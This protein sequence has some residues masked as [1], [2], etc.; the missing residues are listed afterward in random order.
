MFRMKKY[1]YLAVFFSGM[2]SLAA[3]FGAS[4]LLGNYFGTSNIIWACIIGLILIYLTVGYFLGGKWA[5]RSPKFK[6]FFTILCWAAF[7]VGL[8]PVVSRP[9]LILASQAFEKL[10]FGILIGAFFSV[11]VLFSIPVTLLGTASPFAIRLSVEDKKTAGRI[12]GRIYAISTLGSFLG[13]FLPTLLLIPLIGTYRTFL[14]FSAVLLLVALIGMWRTVSWRSALIYIWMPVIIIVLAVIGLP[15]QDK[16]T[17]GLIF[18]TESAYNYIQVQEVN[19]NM[20]LRL[21]EGEGIHSI[22]NPEK[23]LTFGPWDQVIAAPFF[24]P[25]MADVSSVKSMA[26]V[27]LAAGTTARQATYFFPEIQIDGFEIDPRIIDVAREYFDMNQPNLNVIIQDGRIGLKD[28][29]AS[30]Q[31]ISVDAYRPPYIPWQLTTREFFQEVFDRL[32]P[33]GVMVINVGRSP[34]DRLLVNS[35]FNTIRCVF[36]SAYVVDVPNTMNSIVFATALPTTF[37]SF[38]ENFDA[39][40]YDPLVDPLLLQTLHVTVENIQPAPELNANLVFTDDH[41]PVEWITNGMVF[42]F[43]FSDEMSLIR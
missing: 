43:L 27:G 31:I 41:A 35:L 5:D 40:N 28:S 37:D 15:G 12:S 16:E 14:V 24:N 17:A 21:N 30:Y 10:S 22:Y 33:D 1:L 3:E 32:T 23:L 25:G 29:N 20:L 36:P 19:G 9:I 34:S 2:T 7:T 39:A 4:R 13:T 6:T 18:E 11:I 26:I 8:I 42:R 38:I